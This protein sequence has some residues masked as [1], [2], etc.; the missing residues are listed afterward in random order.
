MSGHGRS[1]QTETSFQWVFVLIGG[2]ALLAL[3]LGFANSCADRGQEEFRTI[4]VRG[5]VSTVSSAAWSGDSVRNTTLPDA[6]ITCRAGALAFETEGE[7]QYLDRSPVFLPPA[8]GGRARIVTR[9]IALSSGTPAQFPVGGVAYALDARSAYLIIQ[10]RAG[11]GAALMDD[12]P[13]DPTLVSVPID[14]TARADTLARWV[15]G[16]PRT[17]VIA[18]VGSDV[19]LARV[20]ASAISDTIDVRGVALQPQS[21]HGGIATIYRR[22]PATGMLVATGTMPYAHERLGL[23]VLIS[24]DRDA[25]R[26]ATDA[27]ADRARVIVRVAQER[28]FSLSSETTDIVCGATLAD[29]SELLRAIAVK[30]GSGQFLGTLFGGEEEIFRLQ[31]ILLTRP[32]TCPGVS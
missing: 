30:P 8:V 24:A 28:A 25:A 23:G 22:E 10:D 3:L 26:C 5:A 29:A 12:L 6:V 21:R 9:S 4:G 13:R 15:P 1:G 11:K 31:S 32:G 27:F 2:V 7:P 19:D 20:D 14:D 17:V 16:S 18:V